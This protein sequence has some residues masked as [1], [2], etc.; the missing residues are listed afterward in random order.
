MYMIFWMN[1]IALVAV[2]EAARFTSIH[3][4]NLST[5]DVCESTFSFLEQTNQVKPQR[6]EG[7]SYWYG[8]QLMRRHTFLEGK[9]L[10]TLTPTD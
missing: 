5:E 4:M 3:S 6:G 8:L 10:T 2:I 7:P 9:K 1:S